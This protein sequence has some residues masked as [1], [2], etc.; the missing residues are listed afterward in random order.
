MTWMCGFN[1]F[2]IYTCTYSKTIKKLAMDFAEYYAQLAKVFIDI[3]VHGIM[4][5][6]Y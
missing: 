1:N 5:G 3:G 4:I 2:M 6:D